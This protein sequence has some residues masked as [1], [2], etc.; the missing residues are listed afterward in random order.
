MEKNLKG[1]LSQSAVLTF[2]E[3]TFMFTDA[4]PDPAQLEAPFEAG[5]RLWFRGPIQGALTVC[6]Y[7]NVLLA[8]SRNML[9]EKENPSREMQLDT[10]KEVVNVICGNLLPRIGGEDAVFDLNPPDVVTSGDPAV[11][12]GTQSYSVILGLEGGRAELILDLV[13]E[14]D[15]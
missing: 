10:L 7:G 15:H 11:K 12:E 8:L 1:H 4:E 14:M 6:L 2:E 3:L 13:V 9:A 5:A